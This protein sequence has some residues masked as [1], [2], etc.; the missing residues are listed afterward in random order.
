MENQ[1]SSTMSQEEFQGIKSKNQKFLQ[2]H[3]QELEKEKLSKFL[4]DTEDFLL[5][6]VY[7][8]RDK[9]HPSDGAPHKVLLAQQTA[10]SAP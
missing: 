2:N 7:Q 8:W 10:E 6:R 5:N 4:R 1:L 9:Q 3:R